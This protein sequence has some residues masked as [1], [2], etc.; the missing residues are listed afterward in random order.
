MRS[1]EALSTTGDMG[2][3]L[4][5]D[6]REIFDK[7]RS[8][9]NTGLDASDG[10]DLTA[11]SDSTGNNQVFYNGG[12]DWLSSDTLV[13][14]DNRPSVGAWSL[15]TRE[16][17]HRGSRPQ[18]GTSN[19]S[20]QQQVRHRHEDQKPET[21]PGFFGSSKDDFLLEEGEMTDD[22]DTQ[23]PT[24][25]GVDEEGTQADVKPKK[26]RKRGKK[27]GKRSNRGTSFQASA[28]L[29]SD[30]LAN[31]TQ[32]GASTETG[33]S[34]TDIEEISNLWKT[35][36]KDFYD[37]MPSSAESGRKMWIIADRCRSRRDFLEEC[38][39]TGDDLAIESQYVPGVGLFMAA[40]P[41]EHSILEKGY[42]RLAKYERT[43]VEGVRQRF[44]VYL[45]DLAN[46]TKFMDDDSSFVADKFIHLRHSGDTELHQDFK[47][48]ERYNQ[49]STSKAGTKESR[50][51]LMEHYKKE[52]T[53]QGR[54]C[55]TDLFK[56][57]ERG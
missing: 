40:G 46:R 33:L 12:R 56:T 21:L 11:A 24:E 22:A 17:F 34:E 57:I 18:P 51:R 20:D 13:S 25:E 32:A 26:G 29:A 9:M 23:L 48:W 39:G 16:A 44:G 15:E 2:S 45:S 47:W 6:G 50:A 30:S 1:D 53:E 27:G 3:E 8:L 52:I 42:T 36:L 31:P 41:P 37:F 38:L 54:E 19:V 7:L 35:P 10:E 14:P 43:K 55:L 49:V 28:T 4:G 5:R